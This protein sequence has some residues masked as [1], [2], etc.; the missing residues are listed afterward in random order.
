MHILTTS[1]RIFI[2]K[3]KKR[4]AI[5]AQR[6]RISPQHPLQ[7]KKIPTIHCVQERIPYNWMKKL[8]L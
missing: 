4:G 7:L 8:S 2:K 1:S 3:L 5:F 6:P